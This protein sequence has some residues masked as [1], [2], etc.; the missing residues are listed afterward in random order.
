M[1]PRVLGMILA[2]GQGSRLAPLTL[3][4]SKPAVPFGG[5]YRIIDFA[6]NN[7][8]NSGVFS[9]YVLTQYKAQ[10]LT[11]HIQRG[12][13][14]GTF[15][16]DYFITLVPAQMYR[17]E[18]L[19]AVWYRGTADAV[20]QNLHLIDNF[21]AD[22][23]AIFSGDHIY[24]MNVEHMLQAHMDARADVTIAAYPM[25]RTRAHQFG[26]MQVDDRWRVTEF[27]EKPQDPPGLPGD[28]D[29][30]LTS[31]GNYIFSRRA[32]EELLHTS[33]SGEGEGFDFGHNV[34]PRA[35]ADGYHVQAYD[36]HRNPIPGQSS[37]NLY[38]R[39]VGTLDAYFE[40]SMDLVSVNP[41]F[42]IYN[43]QWPLRTSSEFSPPAKFVH[44]AEGRKGQAFNSL[45][46]GGVII[47]GGTV[48]DSI[49]SRNVR[50]HSYSLV[51]SCVLFDNVEVGRHSHLRRVIVDKDVIIPPGTRIGLDHEEDRGRGFTVT[52]NGIVVVPKS[53]TF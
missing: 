37:P 20:Y 3:K 6:I 47:S 14:F 38:W 29:T 25:P 27:L 35:L 36:F 16:Q 50:T 5:K 40:A 7:F 48:R 46:A 43:P 52:N 10:S 11:E 17:Y 22:Y 1:K 8:I 39:D 2:G 42:D 4:R 51:E 33:I 45:L 44:E 21:N 31:M 19:G 28:P 12:W 9:I 30:S 41:E 15:L 13:R 34:L 53:Y 24:K 23:V 32:L 26:V 49:L 18:E